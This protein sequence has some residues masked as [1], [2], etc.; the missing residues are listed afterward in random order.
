ML[1]VASPSGA[2]PFL[3]PHCGRRPLQ[4]AVPV[5]ELRIF[6]GSSTPRLTR[7]VVLGCHRCLVLA[8]WQGAGELIRGFHGVVALLA[9]PF[10][11][12]HFLRAAFWTL[13]LPFVGP[14]VWL[15]RSLEDAG[16]DW[17]DFLRG[18]QEE[19][20][21]PP[22]DL[23][24][25]QRLAEALVTLLRDQA[26]ASGATDLRE[27]S[28]VRSYLRFF[29]ADEPEIAAAADPGPVPLPPPT[30]AEIERAAETVRA[31]TGAA[32]ARV[33]LQ[34]LLGIAEQSEGV[35]EAELQRLARIARLC[36]IPDELLGAVFGAPPPLP[37][38]PPE[39]AGGPWTVLGLPRGSTPG[40]IRSRYLQLV[41]EHH[42]DR[43]A[44]LGPAFQAAANRR[45]AQ[46]NDAYRT[47][48]GSRRRAAG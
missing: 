42:P 31:T 32:D 2:S 29:W 25:R 35:V 12:F 30:E 13:A 44:H 20:P 4:N 37:G 28:A 8:L 23:H 48:T 9:L 11:L 45:M 26:A 1:C 15:R 3:C 22:L 39:P 16:L 10:A 47:L 38:A 27:W 5:V 33:L 46:I 24:Q 7:V 17:R 6:P 19:A 21:R 18:R 34:M 40:Q 41:R 43:H 36:G 14:T